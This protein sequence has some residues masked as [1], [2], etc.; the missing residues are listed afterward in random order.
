MEKSSPKIG[1]FE[2]LIKQIGVTHGVQKL[3][4][5]TI[6][7]V[8]ARTLGKKPG[9]WESECVIPDQFIFLIPL[10]KNNATLDKLPTH[11]KSVILNSLIYNLKSKML[12]VSGKKPGFW[13]YCLMWVN[14]TYIDTPW[15]EGQGFL[16]QRL[17]LKCCVLKG[18]TPT[19]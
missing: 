3:V 16:I 2:A 17:T 6:R 15:P 13:H 8:G 12:W 10:K 14:R 11:R 4:F 1:W 5:F 7:R 18:N 19:F 9:F